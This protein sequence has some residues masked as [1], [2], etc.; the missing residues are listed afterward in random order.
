MSTSANSE[1]SKLTADDRGKSQRYFGPPG[2]A[3]LEIN[4]GWSNRWR[5]KVS[6][7]ASVETPMRAKDGYM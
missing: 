4:F 6:E 7:L 2:Q 3:N 5:L 1:I